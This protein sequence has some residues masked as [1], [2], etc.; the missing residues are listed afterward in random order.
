MNTS[1]KKFLLALCLPL[2]LSPIAF[3]KNVVHESAKKIAAGLSDR[4]SGGPYLVT[5]ESLTLENS[6]RM[7]L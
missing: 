2:F 7:N 6:G 4:L 1:L 3:S 5:I